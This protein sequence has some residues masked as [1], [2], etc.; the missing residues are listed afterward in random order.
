MHLT[1]RLFNEHKLTRRL[2]LLWACWLI[3]VVVLRVTDPSVLEII[4]GPV[5]TVV[6]AVIGILATV[7]AFYQWGRQKDDSNTS[8]KL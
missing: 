1:H 6:S 8:S 2:T 5:A 7:I 3:T 4:N